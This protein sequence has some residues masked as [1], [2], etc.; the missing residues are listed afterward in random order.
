V[1]FYPKKIFISKTERSQ[2][3]VQKACK[4][5]YISATVIYPDALYPIPSATKTPENTQEDS[6]DPEPA[7]GHTA[8]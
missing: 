2:G 3:H 5:V 8:I 1:D 6:D 7:D 4:N